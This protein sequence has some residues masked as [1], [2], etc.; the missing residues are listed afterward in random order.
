MNPLTART[1]VVAN[2]TPVVVVDIPQTTSW[3][4]VVIA[5]GAGAVGI[6]F[7]RRVYLGGA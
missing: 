5:L 4:A 7:A 1:N 6:Y 2:R 3:L